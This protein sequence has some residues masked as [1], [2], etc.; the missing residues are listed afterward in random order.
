MFHE[1]IDNN[2]NTEGCKWPWALQ[3]FTCS[4]WSQETKFLFPLFRLLQITE[5]RSK[6]MKLHFLSDKM[7]I[8][9]PTMPW[10]V[11]IFY[12]KKEIL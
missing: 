5:S 2:K 1:I 6:I 9:F 3:D 7:N 4:S 11:D 8:Y 12:I 10:I